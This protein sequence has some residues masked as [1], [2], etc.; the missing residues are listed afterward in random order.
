MNAKRLPVSNSIQQF[1]TFAPG[2]AV[3]FNHH[4]FPDSVF[5]QSPENISPA[6]LKNQLNSLAQTILGF[7]SCLALSVSPGNLRANC[8]E[9]PLGS[10]FNYC[11]EFCFQNKALS[12]I[13]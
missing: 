1:S 2:L 12:F 11:G 13:D 5:G 7:L 8:P 3:S 10:G 4:R 6:I 9:S